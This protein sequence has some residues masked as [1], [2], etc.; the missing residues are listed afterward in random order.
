MALLLV[1]LSPGLFGCD[2][3]TDSE[4]SGETSLPSSTPP[5]SPSS[6]S[7]WIPPPGTTFQWILEEPPFNTSVDAQVYDI[8]LFHAT[9]SL[10]DELHA[11][12]KKVYCYVSVGSY[13]DWR[14]DKGS[15]PASLLG[16][17]YVGWAGEK[18]LDIRK[19]DLLGPI[20]QR[21]FNMCKEKGFD[22]LEPDNIDAYTND[23]GFGL[24]YA[25]QLNFNKWVAG[26]VH[27]LG[28]S[29]GLKNDPDQATDLEP[30][31]DW[32]LTEDCLVDGWCDKLQVFIVKNKA[33]FQTEYT[34]TGI[35]FNAA[36]SYAKGKKY[37][38]ILKN[39][40]LDAYLKTCP[41]P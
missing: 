4:E 28:L 29:I 23:S 9:K 12:G 38:A 41:T 35:D 40:D 2:P 20:L 11:K 18:W 7:V 1:S 37:T 27:K 36:C 33:V 6:V 8:D 3:S 39:R 34:D 13:E 32:A 16:K 17:D 24:T 22:G 15:F 21:R 25:D 10:I 14:P 5:S 26:E 19:I 31:F 30:Y